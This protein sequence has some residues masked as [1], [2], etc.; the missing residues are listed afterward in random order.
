VLEVA[1]ISVILAEEEWKIDLVRVLQVGRHVLDEEVEYF[2]VER[3]YSE[4]ILVLVALEDL[5]TE[6]SLE[7]KTVNVKTSRYFDVFAVLG[8]AFHACFGL[9][10]LLNYGP[11]ACLICDVVNNELEYLVADCLDTAVAVSVADEL[12]K[13]SMK[14]FGLNGVVL[15]QVVC[16]DDVCIFRGV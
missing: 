6:P 9:V 5:P 8:D 14:Y 1:A 15:L 3:V 7:V 16:F 11:A 10:K 13:V 4:V 12:F 2:G